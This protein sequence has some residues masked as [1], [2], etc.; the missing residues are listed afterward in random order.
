MSDDTYYTVLDVSETATQL[1]IKTAYRNLLKKIHPDT[2]ATLSLELRRTA[3]DIAK[4]IIEAYSVLSDAG[5]RR[6]YD[7]QLAEY[8][9]QSAPAPTAPPNPPSQPVPT[10]APNTRPP[11]PQAR[12]YGYNRVPFKR[13]GFGSVIVCMV[14]YVFLLGRSVYDKYQTPEVAASETD[15]ARP[16][17]SESTAVPKQPDLSNLTSAERQSLSRLTDNEQQSIQAACSKAY[18]EGPAA[19]DRCLVRELKEWAS[20]PKQPDLSRLTGM[21][22][23]SIRAAC[24]DAKYLE[25]PA[26]YDRCLVLELKEW[27]SGPKRPD[28]SRLTRKEQ[29]SI[30]S[31][32]S[33]KFLHGPAAY[34]QCL[35][36]ELKDRAHS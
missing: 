24:S 15:Q 25:G 26:A 8:R 35:V 5:Q 2:V 6:E 3:E 17:S 27:A 14:L 34:D 30:E 18:L 31:A 9:Q 7:R 11:R 4:E 36:R 19:Y 20:G 12:H 1:Q 28:L 22:D 29:D 32:C 13:F 23:S 33:A 21:E 10:T 16:V